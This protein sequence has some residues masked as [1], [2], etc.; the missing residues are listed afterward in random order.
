MA[1][2]AGTATRKALDEAKGRIDAAFDHATKVGKDF[3]AEKARVDGELAK[4]LGA[5]DE[6]KKSVVV[7]T[8]QADNAK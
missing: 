6:V 7:A 1:K 8:S 3:E 5:T 4:A 2:V